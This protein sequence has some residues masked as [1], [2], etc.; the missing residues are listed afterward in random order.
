MQI[1]PAL[2]RAGLK[3]YLF[4]L[5][6]TFSGILCFFIGK[7]VLKYLHLSLAVS[8]SSGS[9]ETVKPVAVSLPAGLCIILV[10]AFLIFEIENKLR[11]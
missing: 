8:L 10:C 3:Y 7:A 11:V 9:V 4:F 2:R 1:F 6:R 5:V